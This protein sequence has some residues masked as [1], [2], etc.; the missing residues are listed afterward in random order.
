MVAK[1]R[2]VTVKE[3]RSSHILISVKVEPPGVDGGLDT[4]AKEKEGATGNPWGLGLSNL[5]GGSIN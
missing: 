4:G 1:T 2:A 3:V 5:K